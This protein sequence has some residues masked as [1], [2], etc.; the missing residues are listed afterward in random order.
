M[1]GRIEWETDPAKIEEH[2]QKTLQRDRERE[3]AIAR[4]EDPDAQC[5]AEKAQAQEEKEEPRPKTKK[6]R[7]RV[8]RNAAGEE[9]FYEVPPTEPDANTLRAET[10]TDD[11][12][13]TE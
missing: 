6:T 13:E 11:V 3:E 5:R 2:R 8:R 4:G 7:V 12:E 10:N 9:E 1:P